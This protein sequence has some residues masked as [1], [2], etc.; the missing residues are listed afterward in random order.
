MR[1]SMDKM[2]RVPMV[3][4]VEINLMMADT[5]FQLT[6]M[7]PAAERALQALA[8]YLPVPITNVLGQPIDISYLTRR[9]YALL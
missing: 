2:A 4:N 6:F 7:N 5:N 8:E 3:D 9:M 1:Q